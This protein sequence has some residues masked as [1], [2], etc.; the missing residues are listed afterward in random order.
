MSLSPRAPAPDHDVVI[1]GGGIVGL[2][3][4]IA[5]RARGVDVAILERAAR[6]RP[7][8]AAIGL[9]PNGLRALAAVS[10]SVHARVTAAAIQ[11]ERKV[12][13][14]S[15]IGTVIKDTGVVEAGSKDKEGGHILPIYFVWYL[16][17]AYLREA[18]ED[19]VV[20]LDCAVE[21]VREEEDGLVR[22]DGVIRATGEEKVIRARVVLGAD[23]IRSTVRQ[24]CFRPGVVL[25]NYGKFVF[26]A[27]LDTESLE[28]HLRPPYRTG[29]TYKGTEPG[30]LFS[31]REAAPGVLT[32]TAMAMFADASPSVDA[33]ARM[34]RFRATF[35]DY[36]PEVRELLDQVPPEAIYENPVMDF[37]CLDA[38]SVGK[39]CLIGDAAHAITPSLGQGANLGME[40]A[41]EIAFCLA[42]ALV[43]DGENG[44]AIEEALDKFWRGRVE[45]VAHLHEASRHVTAS[46]SKVSKTHDAIPKASEVH[47]RN[48]DFL[49]DLYGWRPSSDM[50]P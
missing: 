28:E 24:L 37:D 40:D 16:L 21:G 41:A 6:L 27:V 36:P 34:H 32:I 7:V 22:V 11:L 8:G 5:L 50:M 4:A 45:R 38:W 23:G 29:F 30:K 18:L 46:F 35:S 33:G 15:D 49:D 14:D 10:P 25:K 20:T 42:P 3:T 12:F 39:V 17:Q 9:F 13:C 31:W 19:D 2:A 48:P 47:P 26:R 1:V 44:T 43:G